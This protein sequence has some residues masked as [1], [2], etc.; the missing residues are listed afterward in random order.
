MTLTEL[1]RKDFQQT[2]K[3]LADYWRERGMS[4]YNQK[5]AEKYILEGHRKE[6][7]FDRF[8]VY[9]EKGHIVGVISLIVQ[10]GDVAEMRDLVVDPQ[11][12]KMG[13]GKKI[14]EELLI[15]SQKLKVR[16]V[17]VLTFSRLTKFYKQLGFKKEGVLKSHYAK[18]ED[19][20][21]MSKIYD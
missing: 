13:Y 18:G 8:F 3:L 10:E 19:L 7:K 15:L 4:K 2:S 12:R 17:H 6:I 21:I 1:T 20:T 5:Y 9:K 14:I 11:Y 16:K